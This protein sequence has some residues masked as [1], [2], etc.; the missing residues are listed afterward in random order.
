M[1]AFHLIQFAERKK[2]SDPFK[3]LQK[4]VKEIEVNEILYK[5]VQKYKSKVKKF[6]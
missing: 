5:L 2:A 1:P 6:N 3:N 4:E